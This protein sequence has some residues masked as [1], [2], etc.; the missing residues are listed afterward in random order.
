MA[1]RISAINS[2]TYPARRAGQPSASASGRRGEP[3]REGLR[4]VLQV[5]LGVPVVEVEDEVAARGI[6]EQLA[7]QGA[8]G[9][10][11]PRGPDVAAVRTRCRWRERSRGAGVSCTRLRSCLPPRASGSARA[12]WPRVGEKKGIAKPVALS[13]R[14]TR[15]E[16]VYGRERSLRASSSR[17]RAARRAPAANPRWSRRGPR[18]AGRAALR[19]GLTSAWGRLGLARADAGKRVPRGCHRAG[20]SLQD[21]PRRPQPAGEAS[22]EVE[23]PVR[24]PVVVAVRAR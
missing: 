8:P 12:G 10:S 24:S 1:S 21:H 19:G 14:T 7:L 23:D 4:E 11:R 13:V 6:G 18:C 20:P 9:R 5:A 17:S 22:L 16:P 2:S 3:D 15:G